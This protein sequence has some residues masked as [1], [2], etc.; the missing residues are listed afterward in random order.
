MPTPEQIKEWHDA[1][2]KVFRVGDYQKLKA[3]SE[4][5]SK[6]ITQLEEDV[7]HFKAPRNPREDAIQVHEKN[8]LQMLKK[9]KTRL[10]PKLVELEKQICADMKETV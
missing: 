7:Q 5:I 2:R 3:L 1:Y 6:Q 9:Q 8:R 4:S 10:E